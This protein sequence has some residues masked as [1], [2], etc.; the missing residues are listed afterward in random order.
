MQSFEVSNL[1]EI[2]KLSTVRL[3]QPPWPLGKYQ[4]YDFVLAGASRTY[5]DMT[6]PAGLKEI[7]TYA[8]ALG[9]IKNEI[10]PQTRDASGKLVM[11]S[12]TNLVKDAHAAGLAVSQFRTL[13]PENNFLPENLKGVPTTNPAARGDSIAEIQAYLATG[14]D[15]FFTDDPAVGRAAV[16]SFKK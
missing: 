15:G 6:T 13:R 16:N 14:I 8:Y 10:I 3:A 5:A 9:P 11:G 4:P 12:P 1:K 7:A 2:S